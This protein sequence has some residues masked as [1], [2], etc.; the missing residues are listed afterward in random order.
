MTPERVNPELK[1]MV[2]DS[3]SSEDWERYKKARGYDIKIEAASPGPALTDH[4]TLSIRTI[5]CRW[6]GEFHPRA[7]TH[8]EAPGY[9]CSRCQKTGHL[10]KVCRSNP[11]ER[12]PVQPRGGSTESNIFIET[13]PELSDKK[14]A[15][16]K[17]LFS[18]SFSIF[19]PYGKKFHIDRRWE[20]S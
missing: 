10:E 1:P 15:I 6:C 16:K 17:V 8:C 13:N 9:R 11:E 4:A 12:R 20:K 2:T 3:E 18:T 19:Y 14:E 5:K 7:K